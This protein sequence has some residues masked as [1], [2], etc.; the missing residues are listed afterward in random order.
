MLQVVID[1][2]MIKAT[3]LFEDQ[4]YHCFTFNEKDMTPTIEEYMTMLC[5]K[6]PKSN[7]ICYREPKKTRY[8]KKLVELMGL[9][10]KAVISK[11]KVKGKS[12][13]IL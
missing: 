8:Q 1:E 7:K 12:D 10:I 4:I 2:A 6:L 13:C 9:E 3:V 5:I 11:V